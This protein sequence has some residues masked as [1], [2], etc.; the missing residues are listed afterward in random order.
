AGARRV[1]SSVRLVLGDQV[2][3]PEAIRWWLPYDPSL[4]QH[5]DELAAAIVALE[6]ANEAVIRATPLESWFPK[7]ER[8]LPDGTLIDVGYR[9]TDFYLPNTPERLGLVTIATLDLSNPQA[10]HP[11]ARSF[12]GPGGLHATAKRL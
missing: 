12:A 5:P 4:D 8:K 6:D 1:G 3:W 2:R 10:G 7:G 9:C 11:R